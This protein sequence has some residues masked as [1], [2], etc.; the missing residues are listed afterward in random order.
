MD[1]EADFRDLARELG[2]DSFV[3]VML[4]EKYSEK[5]EMLRELIKNELNGADVK[6]LLI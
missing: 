5:A 1:F 2:A 6:I 4:P 3:R